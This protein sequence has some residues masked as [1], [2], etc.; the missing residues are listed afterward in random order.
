MVPASAQTNEQLRRLPLSFGQS[1]RCSTRIAACSERRGMQQA[2]LARLPASHF[3][4]QLPWK[5]FPTCFFTYV[6]AS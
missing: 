3:A 5:K 6:L 2:Q 1:G 4:I